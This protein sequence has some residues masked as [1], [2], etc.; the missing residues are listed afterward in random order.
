MTCPDFGAEHADISTGGIGAYNDW[1]LTVI[2]TEKGRDIM[3]RLVADGQIEIRPG[4]DDLG[5]IA[6]MRKLS[7]V[8]R[9]RWPE[10]AVPGPRRMPPLPP[11]QLAPDRSLLSNPGL[12]ARDFVAR[13]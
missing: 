4:D 13:G 5:A 7:R 8:S 2:R 12:G 11:K 6:L 1:T 9:K 3:N 10:T